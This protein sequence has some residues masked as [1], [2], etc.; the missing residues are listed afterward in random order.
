MLGIPSSNMMHPHGC[1]H[2]SG[3]YC[4]AIGQCYQTSK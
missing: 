1:T 3:T 2:L 4:H